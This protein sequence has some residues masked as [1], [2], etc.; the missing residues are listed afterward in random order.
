VIINY[1]AKDVND[2]LY[3]CKKHFLTYNLIFAIY[4]NRGG[5]IQS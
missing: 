3:N 5:V 4:S 2:I 1:L